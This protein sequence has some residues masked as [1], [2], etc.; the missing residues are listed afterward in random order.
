VRERWIL[1][2]LALDLAFDGAVDIVFV[3][4]RADVHRSLT[5]AAP[6]DAAT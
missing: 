2:V 3:L 4:E 5:V 1:T 6:F